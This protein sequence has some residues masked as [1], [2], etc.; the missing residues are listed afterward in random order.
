MPAPKSGERADLTFW[1]F[2]NRNSRRLCPTISDASCS[3]GKAADSRDDAGALKG[4][5]IEFAALRAWLL[6]HKEC[7]GPREGD[8]GRGAVDLGIGCEILRKAMSNFST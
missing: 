2:V 3:S 6:S 8:D 5:V 7:A 4:E 1:G